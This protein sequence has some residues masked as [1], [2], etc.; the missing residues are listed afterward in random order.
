MLNTANEFCYI[1]KQWDAILLWT[2]QYKH[3]CSKKLFNILHIAAQL[4][5]AA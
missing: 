1:W 3:H 4:K 5:Y 2:Q